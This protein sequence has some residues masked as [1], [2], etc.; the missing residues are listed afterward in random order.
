MYGGRQGLMVF[1]FFNY[2]ALK[3]L[4]VLYKLY[5]ILVQSLMGFMFVMFSKLRLDV[6]VNV[7]ELSVKRCSPTWQK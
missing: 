1:I 7:D 6:T 3:S 5:Y 2:I 4:Q